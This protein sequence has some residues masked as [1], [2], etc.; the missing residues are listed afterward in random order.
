MFSPRCRLF[1]QPTIRQKAKWSTVFTGGLLDQLGGC[2]HAGPLRHVT[3]F[4]GLGLLRVLRPIPVASADDVPSRRPAGCW[5]GRG[6]PGWFPR[7][8]PIPLTG[9]A[10]SYAPA[11]SPRLRRSPSS[12][13]PGRRLHPTEEFPAQPCAG[14]RCSAAQIHQVRAAGSLEG[15][16]A[17]GSSRTPFCLACRT[18][19]IWQCW[20]VPSLSGLLSTLTPVSGIGLPSASAAR[21]DEPQAVPFHHRRVRE[22]LV[23]LEV[24]DPQLVGSGGDEVAF[25]QVRCAKRR[26]VPAGRETLL[27]QAGASPIW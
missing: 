16:S 8:L 24:R 10:P 15:R 19:T 11:T 17:A 13:P 25:H 3:G 22:R 9:S 2:E 26:W 7:S 6:P 5:S 18:R 12:W 21:C 14:A 27:G 23:A 1:N 20:P 4:P